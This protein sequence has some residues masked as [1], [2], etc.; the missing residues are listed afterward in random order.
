M[1]TE[2][3]VERVLERWLVDGV[4]EMPSRVFLS[5]VDRVE[6]QPQQRAWRVSWRDS[7]MNAYLKPILA[8]AAVLV[9]AIG[10]I[11]FISRSS[12]VGVGSGPTSSPSPTPIP[13][14]LPGGLINAG[15][16]VMRALQGDPMAFTITAPEGW[17]GFG[18]FFSAVPTRRVLPAGSE[19]PSI[20]TRR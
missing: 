7:T 17:T 9:L 4:D 10:G 3:D 15:D 1:T 14:P 6:R 18:G 13:P 8:I 12:R 2:R 11:A 19:S 16:Y 20:T 5:I